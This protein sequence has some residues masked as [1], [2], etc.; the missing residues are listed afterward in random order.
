MQK[1]MAAQKK[2]EAALLILTGNLDFQKKKV[3]VYHQC[4]CDIKADAIPH[5]IRKDYYHLLRFFEGL[6]V[7]E[8]VSF[9]A[10]RQHT[11]TAEYLN[12]SALAMAVLTLLTRLT[13]WIAIENYL[14][15]QRRVTG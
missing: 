6:F 9:G 2:L 12:E 8:G 10:A 11:V 15:S 7:V 5:C 13:Q 4:L 14:T 1:M 3:A